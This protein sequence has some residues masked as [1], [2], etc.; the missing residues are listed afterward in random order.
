MAE[1]GL[2]PINLTL[3]LPALDRPY[4]NDSH[5][6]C[7]FL[8]TLLNKN[9]DWCNLFE[10]KLEEKIIMGDGSE[11]YNG[12]PLPVSRKRRCVQCLETCANAEKSNQKEY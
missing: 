8:R 1:K 9:Y 10:E 12:K 11:S 3:Y 6:V 7:K 4:C 5:Y 2:I